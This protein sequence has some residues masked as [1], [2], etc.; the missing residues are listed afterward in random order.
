[1]SVVVHPGT[2]TPSIHLSWISLELAPLLDCSH[3]DTVTA[4]EPEGLWREAEVRRRLRRP[5]TER[6]PVWLTCASVG[7]VGLSLA[8]ACSVGSF[9]IRLLWCS[10]MLDTIILS[11][12]NLKSLM[13]SHGMTGRRGAKILSRQSSGQSAINCSMGAPPRPGSVSWS[14]IIGLPL[15]SVA[16]I[17]FLQ[18][19]EKKS[20]QGE[21]QTCE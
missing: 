10:S 16:A 5:E 7:S 21:A 14:N 15:A 11:V 9:L 17:S 6:L 12:T 3:A 20:V 4:A 19:A 13:R 18:F 2:N 8:S 1:M